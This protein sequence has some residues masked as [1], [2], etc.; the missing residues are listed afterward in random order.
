M[1][2]LPLGLNCVALAASNAGHHVELLDMMSSADHHTALTDVISRFNPRLIGISVRN[3][4][5]QNMREPRF[6]LASTKSIVSF[7]RRHSNAPIVVGGAGFSIFPV[8]ALRYLDADM[9]VC[10][11]G[12]VPFP[13]L[14]DALEQ[15]GDLSG[16]AG[17]CFPGKPVQQGYA[18]RAA[19]AGVPMPSPAFW[20]APKGEEHNLWI[21][22]QSRR[23]CPMKC[24]Y[25]STPALEG[26][27]IRKH[28]L[29]SVVEAIKHHVAVGFDRFYFVDNTF[30]L[31]PS[32]AKALCRELITAGLKIHW[33]CIL[34]PAFLDRELARLMAQSGCDEVSLGFESGNRNVLHRLNKRFTPRQVRETS[35]LL[36]AYGIRRTGFLLLGGPGETRASVMESL[37]FAESLKLERLKLTLGIRIY[38]GTALERIAREEGVVT[39]ED[40]LLT[41]RFYLTQGLQEW[42]ESTIAGWMADRPYCCN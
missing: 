14:L 5:N 10:G 29:E 25:C 11:E 36:A 40:D 30:N 4:D 16:I 15:G 6:L 24:S 28:P 3:I 1:V 33:R 12:E 2:P 22:L 26:T 19:L 35:K 27:I 17:L 39:A 41:P 37:A 9:G 18:E 31:P 8:A 32:Y 23:G 42:L 38:P 20:R 34:Y 7:C 13:L 21:P